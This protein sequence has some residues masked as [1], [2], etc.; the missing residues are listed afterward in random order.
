[1][2]IA[3]MP[4]KFRKTQMADNEEKQTAS[5]A[6]NGPIVESKSSPVNLN[7]RDYKKF[8]QSAQ[9]GK[10]AETSSRWVIPRGRKVIITIQVD[11]DMLERFDELCESLGQ[12]RAALIRTFINDALSK[13]DGV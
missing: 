11:P 4:G 12:S 9:T 7:S 6:S 2:T 5:A 3:A 13:A 8:V 1:M 10:E